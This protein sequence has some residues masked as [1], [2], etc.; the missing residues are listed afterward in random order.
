MVVHILSYGAGKGNGSRDM[1]LQTAYECSQVIIDTINATYE[2]RLRIFDKSS[3]LAGNYICE[4]SN[5][6][7]RRNKSLYIQGNLKSL[8]S[9]RL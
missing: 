9:Y 8:R 7:G 1:P 4:V 3:K 6:R 5:L 2:N